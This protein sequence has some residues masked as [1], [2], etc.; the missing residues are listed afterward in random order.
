MILSFALYEGTVEP[1]GKVTC[2]RLCRR[3]SVAEPGLE[4]SIF[5]IFGP[6]APPGVDGEDTR[7]LVE[8]GEEK[9]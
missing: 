3:K 1:W 5:P 8:K 7:A 9:G 6:V 2:P 4:P